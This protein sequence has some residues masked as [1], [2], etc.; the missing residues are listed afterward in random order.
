MR[1]AARAIFFVIILTVIFDQHSQAQTCGSDYVVVEGDT[2][3]KIAMAAYGKASKWKLIFYAN[4]DVLQGK[5][6]LV[7]IGTKIRIPCI[8]GTQ[9]PLPMEATTVAVPSPQKS[10]IVT[11]PSLNQIH[12]LTASNFEP[13]TDRALPKGG[14]ITDVIDTAM[15]SLTNEVGP[16]L[17]YEINWVNDWS[18]HLQPLLSLRAFDVGFP[19]TRPPCEVLAALDQ[20]SKILCRKYFYSDPLFEIMDILWVSKGS[21]ITFESDDEVVGKTYCRPSGHFLYHLDIDGRNWLK[22]NKITLLQPQA[23]DECYRLLVEREVDGVFLSELTGRAALIRLNLEDKIVGLSRPVHIGTLHAIVSKTHPHASIMLYYIN[24]TLK[25]IKESGDYDQ[26]VEKHMSAYW[27]TEAEAEKQKDDQP[28][29]STFS[30]S[31][32]TLMATSRLMKGHLLNR[33]LLATKGNVPLALMHAR[34]PREELL[35]DFAE[36]VGKS[37][38]SQLERL[39]VELEQTTESS[40]LKTNGQDVDSEVLKFLDQAELT[41]AESLRSRPRFVLEVL[42]R[43]MTAAR[44][45]YREAYPNGRLENVE[46]YQDSY[47]FVWECQKLYFSV[48]PQ[49]MSQDPAAAAK[50]DL[51]F[52]ELYRAWPEIMPSKQAVLSADEVDNL[53]LEIERKSASFF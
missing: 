2:L 31:D 20:D 21:P 17:K 43:V 9:K 53:I 37:Q 1:A 12:F 5:A 16:R 24:A 6:S 35:K 14:L 11:S 3:D 52:E 49:L 18:A 39:L 29:A 22:D 25:R 13:F 23:I 8:G 46:E 41:V 19:W 42:I 15:A 27:E 36:V 28:L 32:L 30:E 34:H 47:G 26:I 33:R 10:P 50:I 44:E 4:Q 40:V 51:A 7:T 48:K 38:S 45:E